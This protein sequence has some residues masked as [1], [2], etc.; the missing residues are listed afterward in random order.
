MI[1]IASR[2]GVIADSFIDLRSASNEGEVTILLKLLIEIPDE[3][4][5]YNKE[6]YMVSDLQNKDYSTLSCQV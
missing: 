1:G 4:Y 6:H 3:T 2:Q 5:K